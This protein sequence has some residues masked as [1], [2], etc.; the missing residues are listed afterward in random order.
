MEQSSEAIRGLGSGEEN[1]DRYCQGGLHPVCLHD[2]FK[3][4]RYEVVHK[5]GWGRSSTIWL[6]TD[7]KRDA[8]VALKIFTASSS[9]N[10]SA[11]REVAMLKSF[12][13]RWYILAPKFY[14][15]FVHKGPNGSH[16]CLITD[17]AGPS[18]QHLITKYR[19]RDYR[20]PL[21]VILRLSR[22]L[23]VATMNLHEAGIA[24]GNLSATKVVFRAP[25][26]SNRKAILDIIGMPETKETFKPD[27]SPPG[28]HLPSQL[29]ATARWR[30]WNDEFNEIISF[31]DFGA[32][33]KFAVVPGTLKNPCSL[34]VPEMVFAGE[35]D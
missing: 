20:L 5:L 32:S 8:F 33:F 2:T 9:A 35:T 4:G 15:A 22:Q 3:N 13:N 31:L 25:Q 7:L 28:P 17:F 26:L 6:A 30:S 34:R 1:I 24:H 27:G 19:D 11:A 12:Q 14:K 10:L 29:V 18:L 21:D 16:I 23:I